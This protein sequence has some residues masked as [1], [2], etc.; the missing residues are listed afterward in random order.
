MPPTFDP[1]ILKGHGI[2]ANDY[3]RSRVSENVIFEKPTV[4]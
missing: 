4:H 3:R 2:K 1:K